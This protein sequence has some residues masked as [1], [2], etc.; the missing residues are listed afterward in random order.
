MQYPLVP[1]FG[2]AETSASPGTSS[3]P[4]PTAADSEHA[5]WQTAS[6]IPTVWARTGRSTD[7]QWGYDRRRRG[8]VSR[9]WD[10]HVE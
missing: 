1:S 5:N 3:Q 2:E 9:V 7:P 8:R 6:D 10:T 4:A